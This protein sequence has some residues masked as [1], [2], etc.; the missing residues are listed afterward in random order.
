VTAHGVAALQRQTLSG[1]WVPLQRAHVGRDG[2]YTITLRA[3]RAAMSVRT[4]GLPH[5][6]GAHVSGT[7]RT[8]KIAAR[9]R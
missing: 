3:R 7:S 9:K 2:R 4:I 5:D 1:A 8:V 6:G